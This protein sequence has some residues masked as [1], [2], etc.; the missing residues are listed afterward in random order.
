VSPDWWTIVGTVVGVISLVIAVVQTFRYR[1]AKRLLE[2]LR[3]REQLAIWSLYDL[4]VQAYD[5]TGEAR[6]ALRSDGAEPVKAIEKTA[7]T[8][9]LLNA[10]WLKT[11]E[12]AATLEDTFD[13]AA[14]ERWISLGRLD[15]DW[16]KARARKLLPPSIQQG[17]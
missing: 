1:E 15:S 3:V 14:L 16:R 7:Q 12:H 17:Q 5:S 13:Q 2:Q 10:A 9:A 8:A 4:I 6:T 11:I